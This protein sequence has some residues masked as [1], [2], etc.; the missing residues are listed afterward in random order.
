[1]G[2]GVARLGGANKH[3]QEFFT[4]PYF[5]A[6]KWLLVRNAAGFIVGPGGFGTLDELSEILTLIQTHNMPNTPIVLIGKEY[7]QPFLDWVYNS[8]L[9]HHCIT[10]EDAKLL[11]LT[12]DPDEA[13]RIITSKC[14]EDSP[15]G[16][17]AESKEEPEGTQKSD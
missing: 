15:I 12:D 14:K 5:F 2:I 16:I 17:D 13:C 6:R 11:N 8:A 10:E 3:V 1:M 4:L 7:W 9:K